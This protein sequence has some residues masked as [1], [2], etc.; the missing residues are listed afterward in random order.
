[1]TGKRTSAHKG[2]KRLR[3]AGASLAGIHSVGQCLYAITSSFLEN[4][5]VVA[6]MCVCDQWRCRLKINSC[7]EE[8]STI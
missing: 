4:M 3:Y 7:F 2:A 8:V 5:A 1:M 6:C